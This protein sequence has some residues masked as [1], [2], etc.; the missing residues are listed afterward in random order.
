MFYFFRGK[1]RIH[2][3]IYQV[4]HICKHNYNMLLGHVANIYIWIWGWGKAQN[5]NPWSLCQ[6]R[7]LLK[8]WDW[9]PGTEDRQ[10][11]NKIPNLSS[12]VPQ[13]SEVETLRRTQQH[14]KEVV[15][16]QGLNQERL[17]ASEKPPKG[18]TAQEE[19]NQQGYMCTRLHTCW[20][21]DGLKSPLSSDVTAD[22]LTTDNTFFMG[23]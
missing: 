16:R 1:S 22:M 9:I 11:R 13:G 17:T 20:F 6:S 4:I 5:M 19:R 18:T 23:L 2:L 7:T 14:T 8:S 10:R 3:Q 12:R 15:Q 21:H